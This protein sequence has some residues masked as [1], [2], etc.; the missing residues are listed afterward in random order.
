MKNFTVVNKGT[1]GKAVMMLTGMVSFYNGEQSFSASKF[2]NDF[3]KLKETHNEIHID[4]V[5]LYGGSITEGIPV[6][7]HLKETA[8][9]GKVKITGKIDGLAA[10]M[11]SIIAMAIPVENLEWAI[12]PAL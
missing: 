3:N 1:N 9:E 2:I 7:N 4:I 11:G 5:N 12:W 6:Y 8:E 10:S